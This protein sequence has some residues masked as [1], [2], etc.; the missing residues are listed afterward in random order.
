MGGPWDQPGCRKMRGLP[1]PRLFNRRFGVVHASHFNVV[2]SEIDRVCP[3]ATA[4]VNSA[5]R[6]DAAAF[7]QY[8]EFLPRTSIPRC[9]KVAVD[10]FI[11]LFHPCPPDYVFQRGCFTRRSCR[12]GHKPVHLPDVSDL[13]QEFNLT[14]YI[15][16]GKAFPLTIT[17]P[18]ESTGIVSGKFALVLPS[19]RIGRRTFLV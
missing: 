14:E 5:A 7:Y 19:I 3:C 18:T 13:R 16:T 1:R 6:L 11:Q 4:E 12:S 2:V 10:E 9:P 8:H 15:C 17:L